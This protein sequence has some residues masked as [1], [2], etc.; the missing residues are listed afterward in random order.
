VDPDAILAAATRATRSKAERTPTRATRSRAERTPT[1]ATRSK[2]EQTLTRQQIQREMGKLKPWLQGCLDKY[3]GEGRLTLKVHIEP[4]GRARGRAQPPSS[5]T[6][7]GNCVAGGL[8]RLSFP[9]FS[10]VPIDIVYPFE[11]P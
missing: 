2:T 8:A 4:S 7:L 6:R 5:K 11:L 3:P 10:G 1:R 9:K